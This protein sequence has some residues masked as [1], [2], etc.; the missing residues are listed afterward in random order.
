MQPT[1]ADPQKHPTVRLDGKDYELKFRVSDVVKLQKDHKID[2]FVPAEVSGIEAL[3]KLGAVIAAG[4]AHTGEGITP[5]QVMD[6]ME[7][8]EVAVYALAV[9]EAQ[10][11][12]SPEAQAALKALQAM[13]PAKP[14]TKPQVQ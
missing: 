5:E 10:K 4:I 13:A 6:S 1:A 2:L 7:L 3:Q 11:K 14:H 9:A 8:G 12:V